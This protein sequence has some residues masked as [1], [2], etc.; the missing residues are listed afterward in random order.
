MRKESAFD[1]QR[2]QQEAVIL[3]HGMWMGGW[4]MQGL[5][6]LLSRLP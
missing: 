4:A 2:T 6:L 5:R 3:A 1:A